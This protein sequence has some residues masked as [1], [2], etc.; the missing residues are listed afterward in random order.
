[1]EKQ[2]GWYPYQT[3]QRFVPYNLGVEVSILS[4]AKGWLGVQ[5]G[6]LPNGK[7]KWLWIIKLNDRNFGRDPQGR[8]S[9]VRRASKTFLHLLVLKQNNAF[10]MDAK[11]QIFLFLWAKGI[12]RSEIFLRAGRWQPTRRLNTMG[13]AA[14]LP[15]LIRQH[16]WQSSL[17]GGRWCCFLP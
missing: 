13:V 15:G 2:D 8:Y 16:T 12:A 7:K 5:L 14:G 11:L 9:Y 4:D 6:D 10:C 1:M 17:N 3:L